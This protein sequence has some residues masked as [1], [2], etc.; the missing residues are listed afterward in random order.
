MVPPGVR[1]ARLVCL[2]LLAALLFNYPLIGVF[3]APAT[4]LGVPVLYAYLFAAWLAVI[5][6][7]ALA[8][9]RL[10]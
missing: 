9:R 4:I 2:F 10:A 3:N 5:V 6:L 8:V 7:A 1:A